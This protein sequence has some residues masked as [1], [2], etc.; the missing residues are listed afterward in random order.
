MANTS[1]LY[2]NGTGV[3]EDYALEW[4]RFQRFAAED[5]D[6][7]L[8]YLSCMY[9]EGHGVPCNLAAAV[10]WWHHNSAAQGLEARMQRS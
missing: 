7:A 10:R 9:T 2:A 8:Y 1:I 4:T 5:E 6:T 3:S